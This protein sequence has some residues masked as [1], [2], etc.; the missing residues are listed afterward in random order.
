M[1]ELAREFES[2]MS[3]SSIVRVRDSD[4]R[5]R[6]RIELVFEGVFGSDACKG[7]GGGGSKGVGGCGQAAQA[8]RPAASALRR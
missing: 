2:S 4:A 5:V 1:L 7:G 6:T 8:A 3:S